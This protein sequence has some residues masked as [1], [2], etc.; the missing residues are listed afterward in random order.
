M[1]WKNKTEYEQRCDLIQQIKARIASVTQLSRKFGVSRKTIYKW[2]GRYQKGGWGSMR[3]RPPVAQKA[4]HKI[5][6]KWQQRARQ[7]R[8]RHPFWGPRKLRAILVGTSGKGMVPSH[9]TLARWLR[10]WRLVQRVRRQTRHGPLIKA[11]RWRKATR[12]NA[13]WTADFKGW[14]R[15]GDGTRIEPLTIRD[16]RSRYVLKVSLLN[17]QSVAASLP[18]FREVF[19]RYG[20][21]KAI[22]VDN[23]SPFGSK[24]PAGLTR[25]SAWWVLLGIE[26]QFI[27][28]GH[29]EDNGTHEQFHR[30]MKDETVKN[31]TKTWRGQQRRVQRWVQEYNRKRPHEAL[32]MKKPDQ[33]YRPS[34]RKL[35]KR[36]VKWSYPQGWT[37]RWVKSNGL[38]HWK[39]QVIFVGEAFGKQQIALRKRS[40][41]DWEIRYCNL[42]IGRW[43][44]KEKSMRPARYHSGR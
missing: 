22:R 15:L 10:R 27:R 7:L 44:P 30:V 18:I 37:T 23:G 39:G 11:P 17:Q 8:K 40:Q 35:S 14:F 2:V 41:G 13:V 21:P 6:G 31:P 28:P 24:G 43:E 9:S 34:P 38:M 1:P 29:P 16:L 12:A 4:P 19:S 42:V 33:L 32:K 26:V 20:M 3:N 25:L 5:G 36:P